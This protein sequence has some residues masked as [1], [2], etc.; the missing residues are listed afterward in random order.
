LNTQVSIV[1]DAFHINGKPTYPARYYNGYKVEGLLLVSRMITS[2][3]DDEN[4][5]TRNLWKYPDTGVWD[6]DRNTQ[7]LVNNIPTYGSYGLNTIT[8]GLQGGSALAYSA[9]R[10]KVMGLLKKHGVDA[11]KEEVYKGCLDYERAQPWNNSAFRVDGSLKPK[12]MERL[13]KILEAA[14]K[15]RMIVILV[16]FY[17][18]MDERVKNEESVK[19]AVR[20]TCNWVLNKGYTNV[21]IEINNEV[22]V[23]LYEHEILQPHR[24]HE[25]IELTKTQNKN[26]RR[27]LVGTSYASGHGK[28]RVDDNVVAASDMLLLHGNGVDHEGVKDWVHKSR[29]QPSYR[30]KP[31]LYDEDDHYDFDKQQNNFKS[32]ISVYAGWGYFDNGGQK[33]KQSHRNPDVGNY[34]DGYQNVP[35]NWRL[36]SPRKKAFFNLVKEISGA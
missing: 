13:S 35:V 3:F 8:V 9:P 19:N 34:I 21:L 11:S 36:S 4:P 12:Y 24:V 25:L 33:D 28:D 20:N 15:H 32:A 6:P 1:G 22:N 26:G 18:G 14:D 17:F 27:L 23:P 5:Y 29:E 2:I 30:P 31:V 16:L 10:E 7:E